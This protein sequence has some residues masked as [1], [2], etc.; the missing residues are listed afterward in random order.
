MK[1]ID[2]GPR[3]RHQ[4]SHTSTGNS[5]A[6]RQ[7]LNRDGSQHVTVFRRTVPTLGQI[8][9]IDLSG[10]KETMYRAFLIRNIYGGGDGDLIPNGPFWWLN[11]TLDGGASS[12]THSV[13]TD[14]LGA[15]FF[16]RVHHQNSIMTEGAEKYGTA[17]QSLKK[18]LT[19]PQEAWSYYTLTAVTALSM[20]EVRQ[21]FLRTS[22][23]PTL[24]LI[25][26]LADCSSLAT[27]LDQAR[28]RNRQVT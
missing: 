24:L 27:R 25:P 7:H 17:L 14:A 19:Q 28:W 4:K 9:S 13:S 12:A 10:F 22:L 8:N 1:Y 21:F 26:G 3:V 6:Q 16:G 15:A 5:E 11:A 2:E 18:N 23:A 20:Y